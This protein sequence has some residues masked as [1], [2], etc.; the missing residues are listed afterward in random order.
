V[1]IE[2][3]AAIPMIDIKQAIQIA[4]A[5]AAEMLDNGSADLEEV[6]RE[7]YKSHDVWTI[8]LSIPR[9][10]NQLPVMARLAANPL[11][12]KRF[13]ID[14]ETGELLAMKLRETATQ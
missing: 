2:K 14:A 11:Q 12:Y 5:K 4:K 7:S 8:T 9:D 1:S 13:F 10:V 3:S 6:E